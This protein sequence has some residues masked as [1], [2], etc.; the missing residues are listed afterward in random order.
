M[1]TIVVNI[2]LKTDFGIQKVAATVES[3]ADPILGFDGAVLTD[4]VLSELFNR[5][6]TKRCCGN[7]F[8]SESDKTDA[9]S[10][11]SNDPTPTGSC[12]TSFFDYRT[13]EPW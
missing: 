10:E 9:T 3:D 11:K 13:T 5:F 12:P 7:T 4:R 2:V 6:V 8:D 1:Q